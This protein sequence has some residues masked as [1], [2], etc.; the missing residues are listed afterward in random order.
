MRT[1]KSD[2]VKRDD[3]YRLSYLNTSSNNFLLVLS[4]SQ[5]NSSEF[6]F[7]SNK[8]FTARRQ[9]WIDIINL[10]ILTSRQ[11]PELSFLMITPV[12]LV[13]KKWLG[14]ENRLLG[15]IFFYPF[16]DRKKRYSAVYLHNVSLSIIVDQTN[17]P[18]ATW[19]ETNVVNEPVIWNWKNLQWCK[20]QIVIPSRG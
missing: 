5:I 7:I 18:N 17:C 8:L 2:G 14:W 20:V 6:L 19:K 15:V 1:N 16:H 10:K 3:R 13:D 12:P 9:N 4:A 11:L